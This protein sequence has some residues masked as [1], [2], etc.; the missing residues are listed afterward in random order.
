ML[1]G[2]QFQGRHHTKVALQR[3]SSCL[4]KGSSATMNVIKSYEYLVIDISPLYD[5]S[6]KLDSLSNIPAG[7]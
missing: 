4:C 5:Q 3:E 7:I 1:R 6:V 2:V